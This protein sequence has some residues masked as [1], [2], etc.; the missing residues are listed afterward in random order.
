MQT[1]AALGRCRDEGFADGVLGEGVAD[2]AD[3]AEAGV[4][5]AAADPKDAEA[6]EP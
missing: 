3:I 1:D 2:V 4:V 6:D 5:A